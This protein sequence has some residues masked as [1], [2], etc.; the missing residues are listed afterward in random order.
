M[1]NSTLPIAINL[2]WFK[3]DFRYFDHEPLC[4]AIETRLPTLLFYAFE[5]HIINAPE[6]D[7][8]HQRFIYQSITDL[9]IKLAQYNAHIYIFYQE[10]I[11]ILEILSSHFVIKHLYSHQETNIRIT[12]ERDKAVSRFCKE[13]GIIW[14]ESQANGVIRGIK[15]RQGWNEKWRSYMQKPLANPDLNALQAI[16]LHQELYAKLSGE[17]LPTEIHQKS[18][19]F[20][21]GGYTKAHAYMQSFLADRIN[22]YSKY[23]SKPEYSRRGCS[24]LSPYIAFGCLSVRQVYQAY[25]YFLNTIPNKRAAQN[26]AS[27]LKWHCHFIQK[28]EMEDRIEFENINRAYNDIRTDWDETL[29]EAWA[30]GKTG[31]PLVDAAMRCVHA[32]GYLNFRSR[33]MLVSF[34]THHLWLDWKRGATHLARLFLD[35]EPGIHYPQFN[36]QAGVTG[37]NIVRIYN[38]I[39]QSQ[40]HDPDGIFIQKWVPELAHLP[41]SLIHE[42]YKLTPLEQDM[43]KCRIGADYPAPIINIEQTAKRARDILFGKQ[44]TPQAIQENERILRMHTTPTRSLGID[45]D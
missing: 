26:F 27:R 6:H 37:I 12:Y 25:L 7:I 43:Y 31:F 4:K 2:L 14:Q 1:S 13:K 20:Q 9:N 19:V 23:L 10:I 35:F 16:Q 38:P 29:F 45:D 33:S 40:E 30:H 39:K 34:L 15:D 8:R 36:M 21:P 17:L 18:P 28:F 32:T 24:R 42:P 11:P 3:R 22:H 44:K 41:T 5:P